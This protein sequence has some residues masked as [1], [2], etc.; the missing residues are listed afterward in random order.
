MKYAA[1]LRGINVGGNVLIKMAD[2]GKLLE[3]ASF[4]NVQ[5]ILASGNVVFESTQKDTRKIAAKIEEF[6][7]K[8]YKRSV[9][10]IVQPIAD[11]QSLAQ[12]N[13]F[14]GAEVTKGTRLYVTFLKES[15][16]MHLKTSS[17]FFHVVKTCPFA[18]C[19]VLV[20]TPKYPGRT[21]GT[22]DLMGVLEKHY[23]KEVTTR[24]WNT[25]QKVLQT[26]ANA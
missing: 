12:S 24:N 11:I 16:K 9:G 21:D 15:A 6:L 3:S 14:K 5:T 22:Q 17:E 8:K 13:P 18:V 1:F 4:R 23:G 2:L 19:A 26:A 25:V 20:L 10:V 7:E